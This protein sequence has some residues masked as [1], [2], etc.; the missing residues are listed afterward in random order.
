[1]RAYLGPK[2]PTSSELTLGA[3]IIYADRPVYDLPNE[4]ARHGF[5]GFGK[6]V[7][8]SSMGGR[9]TLPG[10]GFYH[11]TKYAVEALSDALRFEVRG[12]GIDV[13]L[14][15]PGTIK[16]GFGDTAIEKIDASATPGSPYAAFREAL[17]A[18]IR[19]VYEG[20]MAALSGTPDDVARV[21]ERAITARR[22]RARYPVTFGATLLMGLRRWLGDRGLFMA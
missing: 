5:P 9:M 20:P 7:N 1:L 4:G 17:K 15:E 3:P 13:I 19:G 8:L 14:I 12:F 10:G 2:G 18:Q 22:P 21:I 11:A 6:I 16:S